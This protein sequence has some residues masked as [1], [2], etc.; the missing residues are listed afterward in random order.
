MRRLAC[1]V[2]V[3]GA[4]LAA[5]HG[6]V[7][8]VERPRGGK[9]VPRLCDVQPAAKEGLC[10]GQPNT[11]DR[12]ALIDQVRGIWIGEF[13]IDSTQGPAD[14]FVCAGAPPAVFKIKG[15]LS[16]GDPDVIAGAGQVIG[17][18]NLA[19]DAK[20]ARVVKNETVPGSADPAEVAIDTD[21]NGS[22]DFMLVRYPCDDS[23]KLTPSSERQFCFDTY[24]ERGKKLVKVHT[25]NIQIC[26]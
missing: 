20:V 16:A 8:R 2:L 22:V 6:R 26:Y 9:A 5:P 21:G 15:A 17:V 1:V 14:P 10:V 3:G 7:V 4:A 12:V 13:R 23:N 18:R 25:D 11:G 24:L 19:I